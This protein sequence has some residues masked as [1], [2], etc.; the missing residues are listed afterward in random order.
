MEDYVEP[1]ADFVAGLI[2]VLIIPMEISHAVLT[3]KGVKKLWSREATFAY[4]L[5]CLL[6]TLCSTFGG[7]MAVNFFTFRKPILSGF[8]VP[9][10]VFI[11]V[12]S[13][14]LIFYAPNNAVEKICSSK[15]VLLAMV[16]LKELFR[17]KKIW[18]AAEV[19]FAIYDGHLLLA[20]FIGLLGAVGGGFVMNTA[21]MFTQP[22]AASSGMEQF[23]MSLLTKYG[24]LFSALYVLE[25]SGLDFVPSRNIIAMVQAIILSIAMF[26]EKCGAHFDPFITFE[27]VVAKIVTFGGGAEK[28]KTD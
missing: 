4:P 24:L 25:L 19:G 10:P 2:P 14:W 3:A 23:K 26:M 22:W 9:R 12:V 21:L 5:A 6:F 28:R 17:T 20:T 13:W 15:I 8:L 16:M 18:M 27:S 7:S 11:T 1:V